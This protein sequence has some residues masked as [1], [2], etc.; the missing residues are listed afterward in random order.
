[1]LT[2]GG[3]G[4]PCLAPVIY[5]FTLSGNTECLLDELPFKDDIPCTAATEDVLQL[6]DQVIIIRGI[7]NKDRFCRY[8]SYY[9]PLHITT[10][11]FALTLYISSLYQTATCSIY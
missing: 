11:Q 1:M 9:N 4:F 3:P 8:Q 7:L 10:L 6:I 5:A 2:Q